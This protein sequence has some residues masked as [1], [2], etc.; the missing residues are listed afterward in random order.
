MLLLVVMTLLIGNYLYFYE[1]PPFGLG[2]RDWL[3]HSVRGW[4][5]RNWEEKVDELDS[6]THTE[7]K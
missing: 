1:K 7:R 6:S 4:F 5:Y 2:G 3:Y